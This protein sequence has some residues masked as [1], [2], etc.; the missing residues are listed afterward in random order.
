[1]SSLIITRVYIGSILMCILLWVFLFLY[2]SLEIFFLILDP[3][4]FQEL[5]FSRPVFGF[6]MFPNNF[7]WFLF[8]GWDISF[9]LNICHS[10]IICYTGD[11]FHALKKLLVQG[12]VFYFLFLMRNFNFLD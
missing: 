1:M 11:P 3:K 6:A 4:C 10:I 9:L 12:F 5:S 8:P 2:Q 7:C